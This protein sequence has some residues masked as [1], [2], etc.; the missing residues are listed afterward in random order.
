[1]TRSLPKTPLWPRWGRSGSRL[2]AVCSSR[3]AAPGTAATTGSTA[4]PGGSSMRRPKPTGR[5]D[6]D[7]EALLGGDPIHRRLRGEGAETLHPG[8]QD[9]LAIVQPLLDVEREDIASAGRAD[10]EGDRDGVVGLVRDRQ[11]DMPHPELLG[12]RRRAPVEADGRLAC[13]EAFDLDVAPA[14]AAH[15]ESE[16]LGDGLLRGPASGERLGPIPDVGTLGRGQDTQI[17]R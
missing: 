11:R 2:A 1:M 7:I 16:H 6:S 3:L 12:A 17:G 13:R 8:E 14:D 10:A 9:T 4:F 15:A 5:R